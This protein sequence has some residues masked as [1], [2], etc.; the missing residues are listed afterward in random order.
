M[1]RSE[2]RA[3]ALADRHLVVSPQ[4]VRNLRR[5]LWFRAVRPAFA[6][7]A[8]SS[9]RQLALVAANGGTP[10]DLRRIVLTSGLALG[11]FAGA[12]GAV[13]GIAAA[14]VLTAILRMRDVMI[15][16]SIVPRAEATGLV[17]AA[18]L[19]GA[20][21]AWLPARRAARQDVVTALG[22]QRRDA[23]PRR[24]VCL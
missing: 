9:T 7:G 17:L 5:P 12:A 11:L 19:L 8:R 1:C 18:V 2:P 22:G 6:V 20:A 14:A 4:K 3:E 21:A 24:A 16:N 23:A 10:R 13:L 15:P